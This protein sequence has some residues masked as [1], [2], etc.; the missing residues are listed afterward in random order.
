MRRIEAMENKDDARTA[1]GGAPGL[2]LLAKYH[3]LVLRIKACRPDVE[4]WQ[5]LQYAR[6]N[7]ATTT[8]TFLDG[9]YYC[10][11]LATEGKPLPWE[12][13]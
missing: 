3:E 4:D 7:A 2:R 9:V 10:I 1:A 8:D 12:T 13:V 11:R 6:K 5:V